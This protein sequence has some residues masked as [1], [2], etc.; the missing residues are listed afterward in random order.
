MFKQYSFLESKD[1]VQIEY[2]NQPPAV[3][4]NG[5][6]PQLKL[7]QFRPIWEYLAYIWFIEQVGTDKLSWHSAEEAIQPVSIVGEPFMV[8][9]LSYIPPSHLRGAP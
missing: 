6:R 9:K 2:N 8:G 3:I 4:G 5:A 1:F 7:G